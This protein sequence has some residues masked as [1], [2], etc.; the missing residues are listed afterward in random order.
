M[1]YKI[2]LLHPISLLCTQ[3]HSPLCACA[4][5]NLLQHNNTI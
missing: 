3:S 4:Q 1:S 2:T 5:N